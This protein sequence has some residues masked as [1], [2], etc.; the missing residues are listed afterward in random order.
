MGVTSREINSVRPWTRM[1]IIATRPWRRIII[2]WNRLPRVQ[3]IA[4]L[5]LT[6]IAAYL[7]ISTSLTWGQR[8]LDD[9]RYGMP[10]TTHI[11][12]F[13]GHEESVGNPTHFIGVNL[14]RQVI[15]L[16]M[17]GGN[18]D[19]V[20]TLSGPYLFGANEELTPV[21]LALNDVDQDGFTDLL[22]TVRNEQIVYLN[23]DG[24]FRLPTGEEQQ[25]VR[26]QASR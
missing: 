15:V 26:Q 1:R 12:G 23:K 7:L 17:P 16:E 14:E 6:M 25:L 10:R 13:V 5:I 3:S 24:E 8:L 11:S 22:V 18:A 9:I 4:T 19:Q 2:V 20:R 21:D